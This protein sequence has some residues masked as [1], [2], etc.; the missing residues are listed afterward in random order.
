MLQL[1]STGQ[2]SAAT[3]WQ[4]FVPTPVWNLVPTLA[5]LAP[6]AGESVEIHAPAVLLDPPAHIAHQDVIQLADRD[7]QT[8][9]PGQ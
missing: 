9:C 4:S 5:R 6:D 7:R 1:A 8:L 2:G 3:Y